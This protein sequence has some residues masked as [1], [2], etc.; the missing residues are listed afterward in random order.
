MSF[1]KKQY[2]M[3]D[4]IKAMLFVMKECLVELKKFNDYLEKKNGAK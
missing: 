4:N 3:E 1:E 2:T